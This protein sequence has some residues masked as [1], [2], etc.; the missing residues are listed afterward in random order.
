VH[1]NLRKVKARLLHVLS[2][3]AQPTW[4]Q[5]RQ[6]P[7]DGVTRVTANTAVV[8]AATVAAPVVVG[9][10][11]TNAAVTA[12]AAKTKKTRGMLRSPTVATIRWDRIKLVTS[13]PRQP[14]PPRRLLHRR[15]QIMEAHSLE[16]VRRY[17][18]TEPK[19][20]K[21]LVRVKVLK[22]TCPEAPEETLPS[23]FQAVVAH[24]RQQAEI[25]DRA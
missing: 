21:R 16:I 2:R 17:S 4:N 18:F 22:I 24:M 20:H 12:A 5:G 19:S 1:S 10:C 9:S 3:Q 23:L 8:T 14:Q 25:R 7:R 13:K 15:R 11:T 6:L